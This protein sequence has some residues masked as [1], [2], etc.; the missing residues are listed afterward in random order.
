[1]SSKI[2]H[3]EVNVDVH[4]MIKEQA[5]NLGMTMKDYMRVLAFKNRIKG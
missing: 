1:M 3:I 5:L 4:Q 2:K